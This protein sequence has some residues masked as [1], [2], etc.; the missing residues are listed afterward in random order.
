[1]PRIRD[2]RTRA[3]SESQAKCRARSTSLRVAPLGRNTLSVMAP[4]S[5]THTDPT[6]GSGDS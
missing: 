3:C 6:I 5:P 4:Q 1:M 2:S